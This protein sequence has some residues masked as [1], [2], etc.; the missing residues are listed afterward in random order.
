M[1][2]P[3][4]HLYVYFTYGMHH[5]C[6]VVTGPEGRAG[7]VLLRGGEVVDGLDLARIA[8]AGR[9]A[10]ATSRAGRPGCAA[11]STWTATTTGPTSTRPP[12]TLEPGEPV[13]AYETG[14]E[15]R[16]A[17]RS[18]PA[19]AVLDPGGADGQQLPAGE[20]AAAAPRRRRDPDLRG[21]R[22][23]ATVVPRC[24]SDSHT[25]VERPERREFGTRGA[26]RVA[27][28]LTGRS[29]TG[30]FLQVAPR[31][32]LRGRARVRLMFEN[33]TVCHFSR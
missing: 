7:A 26:G 17:R 32:G 14:P 28:K 21:S 13:T 8:A 10:T 9:P 20:A 5:C 27:L 33:S 31:P 3:P 30:K 19:V 22:A 23:A 16:A 24:A 1:F 6:N 11:P 12:L 4:G 29:R 18:R 2:G 15:G 25:R